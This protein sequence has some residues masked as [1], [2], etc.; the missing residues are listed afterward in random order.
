MAYYDFPSSEDR[1]ALIVERDDGT[2]IF[3]FD[4]T[5]RAVSDSDEYA[6]LI[7]MFES[8]DEQYARNVHA[9]NLLSDFNND[10]KLLF[11]MDYPGVPWDE[12]ADPE[13]DGYVTM[14]NGDDWHADGIVSTDLPF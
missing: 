4:D 5:D 3:Y 6:D 7:D 10:G 14:F 11:A 9:M 13:G 1:L 8:N 2:S 12:L